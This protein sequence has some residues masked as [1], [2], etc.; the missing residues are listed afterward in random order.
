M[1]E[2]NFVNPPYSRQLKEAFILKGIEEMKK[3]KMSVPVSTST[4]LF[5]DYILSKIEFLKGRVRFGKLDSDGK[6]IRSKQTGTKDSMIVV[7]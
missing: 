3:G 6:F 4:K 2:R 1:G 7:F 5:H